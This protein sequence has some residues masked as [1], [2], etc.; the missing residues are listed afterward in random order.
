MSPPHDPACALAADGRRGWRRWAAPLVLATAAVTAL[1]PGC[2]GGVGSG[3]T[4]TGSFASGPITGFGSIIVNGVRF[5]DSAASIRDDDDAPRSSGELKLGMQVQV[6]GD[7][8]ATDSSSNRTARASSIRVGS[9]MVGPVSARDVAGSTLTVLGQTVVV[10][11]ETVFDSSLPS[12]LAS[13]TVGQVLEVHAQYDAG[14]GRYRASRVEPRAGAATWSLRGLVAAV[15]ATARTLRIGAA[16][17]SIAGAAGTPPDL[18]AGQTVRLLL[19][20]GTDAS[21]RFT[22]TSFGTALRTPPDRAQA[23]LRG[24]VT[25]FT[26]ATSFSVNGQAVDA[27]N[28]S[29]PDGTAGL[30]LGT[31]VEIAGR[32]EQGTLVATAVSIESDERVVQRGFDFRGSISAVNTTALTITVRGE[33]ISTARSDLRIDNGT[34]ADLVV[35]RNVDV[36]AQLDASRTR[37]EATRITLR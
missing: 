35:G 36:K 16:T 4:G 23:E 6:E 17:F 12:G 8:I 11:T 26:S 5:D 34:R 15:D 27:R 32:I 21:G 10:G 30:G 19:A 2:G 25:A 7:A 28:A 3:G 31:R 1:L 14:S 13:I 29:F 22:V 20:T 33:V 18:A 24:F 37:L 9:E